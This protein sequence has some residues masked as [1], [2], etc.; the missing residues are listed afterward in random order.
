MTGPYIAMIMGVFLFSA[1]AAFAEPNS[2]GMDMVKIPAGSF[3]MGAEC[4]TVTRTCPKADTKN[5]AAG[6]TPSGVVCVGSEDER[7]RHAVTLTRP[8]YLSSTEVTQM[9]YFAVMATNPSHFQSERVGGRSDTYPVEKVSWF[10]AVQFANALSQ[11]EGLPACYN[12]TGAVI[13]GKTVYDCRGYRLPTEAEWEYAARA[14]SQGTRY[15]VLDEIAWYRVNSGKKTNPVGMKTPNAFGLYDMLGNVWEWCH[16]RYEGY[17]KG[18]R[19]NPEGAQVGPDRV[20]RGGSWLFL[21]HGIRA[22]YRLRGEPSYAG[23]VSGFRLARS[24]H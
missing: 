4:K 15:G 11:K 1:P 6:C 5:A 22:A 20:F 7:P 14:G 16:D 2:V 3:M 10:D 24:A 13:G 9:Q 19:T 17:T 8:F 21:A 18:P 23:D 12:S